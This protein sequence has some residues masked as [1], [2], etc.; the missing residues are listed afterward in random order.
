MVSAIPDSP[1]HFS[2]E[3]GEYRSE[4]FGQATF[5]FTQNPAAMF[6]NYLIAANNDRGQSVVLPPSLMDVCCDFDV[7]STE[8]AKEINGHDS[9]LFRVLFEQ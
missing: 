5:L 6:A 7:V 3:P 9:G 1:F 8:I 4:I 2:Q